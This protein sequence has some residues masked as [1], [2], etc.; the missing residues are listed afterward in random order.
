VKGDGEGAT[1]EIADLQCRVK[2]LERL[3]LA[4]ADKLAT[5]A[6]HLALLAERKERRRERV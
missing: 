3:V 4:L 6:E 1:A 5:V 2:E